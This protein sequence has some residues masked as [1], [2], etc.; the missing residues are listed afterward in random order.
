M[1]RRSLRGRASPGKGFARRYAGR[2]E[3]IRHLLLGLGIL[4]IF[5]CGQNTVFRDILAHKDSYDDSRSLYLQNTQW[6]SHKFSHDL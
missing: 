3:K 4:E 6:I 2:E 1:K 5:C